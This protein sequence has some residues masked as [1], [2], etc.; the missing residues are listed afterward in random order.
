MYMIS[1]IKLFYCKIRWRK[2]NRHNYTI[3]V[4]CFNPDTVKVGKMTYGELNIR[5]FGNPYE[6]VEIGSFCSIAQGCVFLTGGEH[7]LYTLS[8][9]PFKTKIGLAEYEEN[10]CKGKIIIGDDVWIG[11]G[12]TILSGVHIGQGAVIAAGTVV[13]KDVPPYAIVGGVPARIIKYRFDMDIVNNM[14]K[15]DYN[16]LRLD[17]IKKN[18]DE[19]YSTIQDVSD[20]NELAEKL[21]IGDYR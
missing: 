20:V 19:L 16:K 12:C 7:E 9:Y 15:L 14:K 3:A 5:H 4:N 17:L 18:V 6:K 10:S 11:Y 1:R 21:N 2:R 8:T 13:N